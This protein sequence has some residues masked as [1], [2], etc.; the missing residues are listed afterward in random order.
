LDNAITPKK[1]TLF[2]KNGILFFEKRLFEVTEVTGD[3]IVGKNN[4]AEILVVIK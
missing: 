4:S 2:L 3:S 1:N